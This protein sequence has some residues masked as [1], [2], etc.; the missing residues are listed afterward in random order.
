MVVN[1]TKMPNSGER[2]LE[3]GPKW[4]GEVTSPQSRFLTQN[5]SYLKRTVGTKMEK[6]LKERLSSDQ[7][8]VGSIS[9]QWGG[10]PRLDTI[11]NV[12]TCL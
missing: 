2:E 8:N 12:I 1:L 6:R 4:R 3:E 7:P 5:C 11:T 10:A 9:R